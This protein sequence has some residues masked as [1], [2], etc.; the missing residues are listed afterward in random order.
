MVFWGLSLIIPIIAIFITT[1]LVF[2]SGVS[3]E[4]LAREVWPA[5]SK[6]L[7]NL[8]EKFF[9][10][11]LSQSILKGYL[12]AFILLGITVFIYLIGEKYLG[13]WSL[14]RLGEAYNTLL[15]F[16]PAFSIF[17]GIGLLAAF[18]EEFLYRL[19]GISFFKKKFKKFGK[20]KSTIL[21]VAIITIIWA[22]A[23]ST[24][25][26]FPF[27][28]R[29]LELLIG[30]SIFGY[31]FVRYNIATTITAH[32]VF[33]TVISLPI[34]FLGGDIVHIITGVFVVALPGTVLLNRYF[35]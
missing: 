24:Y 15:V 10:K 2:I 18:S 29:A 27:Y 25:P 8:G 6:F 5:K 13:V 7:S 23:H 1:T 35:K 31:F 28:F 20:N 32:Y 19:F 30:G 21:A 12:I 16:A 4:A 9:S 14:I 17:A 33:N 26:V 22:V 3:G 34:L 11:E